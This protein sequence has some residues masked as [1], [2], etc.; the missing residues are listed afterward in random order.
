M[1]VGGQHRAHEAEAVVAERHAVVGVPAPQHGPA[2]LGRDAAD[3]RAVEDPARREVPH[4]RL[5]VRLR[6]PLHADPAEGVRQDVVLGAG[7]RRRQPVELQLAQPGQELL[8]VLA[9]ERPEDHLGG[10]AVPWR[11]TRA[12]ISPV[13]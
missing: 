5:R 2:H 12:S 13:R 1:A 7:D 11:E 10:A 9:A 3:G 8:E 6:D 4:P